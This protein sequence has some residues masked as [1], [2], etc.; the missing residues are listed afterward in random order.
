MSCTKL[1]HKVFEQTFTNFVVI[2]KEWPRPSQCSK[3]GA[4]TY[5]STLFC[6]SCGAAL[7]DTG[8]L[9]QLGSNGLEWSITGSGTSY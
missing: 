7:S 8:R 5:A 2:G 4:T 3:C 9:T 6:Q 1:W